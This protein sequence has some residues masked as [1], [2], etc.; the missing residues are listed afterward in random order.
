[1][2]KVRY[3]NKN[4]IREAMAFLENHWKQGHILAHDLPLMD[5]LHRNEEGDYNIAL[6]GSSGSITSFLGFIPTSHFDPALTSEKDTWLAIWKNIGEPGDGLAV[7]NEVTAHFDTVGSIGINAKV[8]KLYRV[9]GFQLGQLDQY[10]IPN[11]QYSDFRIAGLPAEKYIQPEMDAELTVLTPEEMISSGVRGFYHPLKSLVF[12]E[13]RYV[14]HPYYKYLFLGVRNPGESS[15]R[16]ILV[17]RPIDING[18][19]CLRI[20][21]V[22]GDMDSWE[23]I[24]GAAQQLLQQTEAEYIDCLNYGVSESVFKKHGFKKADES[25]V[26]P[27]YFEP[28]LQE[29]ISIKLAILNR[30]NVPYVVFKGDSDQDRPNQIPKGN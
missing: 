24:G 28:F 2:A 14:K 4:E 12:F 23:S 6:A 19:R 5:F 3:C 18:S 13:N 27:N 15:Y 30:K 11:M 25:H 21:D 16:G 29:N 1:M 10:Y 26:I 7:F 9:L 20:V 22:L 8:A 17:A